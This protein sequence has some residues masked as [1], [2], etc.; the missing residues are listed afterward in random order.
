MPW[1]SGAM[2]GNGKAIQMT[3]GLDRLNRQP[4]HFLKI[5]QTETLSG[6][7]QANPS[8]NT[9]TEAGGRTTYL[10]GF[11]FIIIT[12]LCFCN[13][14]WPATF[15][16]Y[17]FAGIEASRWQEF[18]DTDNRLLSEN[19]PRLTLGA[20]WESIPDS[21]R[22]RFNAS[23]RIYFAALSYDGQ[24]QSPIAANSNI[25][26]SSTS[27]YSGFS[28]ELETRFN[29]GSPS[30]AGLLN[31][32]VDLWRRDIDNA[33]DAKGNSVSG[34]TEDYQ[35]LY[36]KL[37][38]QKATQ[39]I[40]GRSLLSLGIKYPLKIDEHASG[41]SQ[42]LH[43]DRA[44]SLFVAY[45]VDLTDHRQTSINIYYE[46]LRLS[47]SPTVAGGWYQPRSHQDTVGVTIGT[48]F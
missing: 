10:S 30:L 35:V 19:G 29:L 41:I 20:N 26:I 25:Y 7:H 9:A 23:S 36:S 42:T 14:A 24:T 46:G 45:R 11:I 22:L 8:S 39:D 31:I 34:F 15:D 48:P 1:M 16:R 18:S 40:Y 5:R 27:R 44:V 21:R 43:P 37:G 3:I 2:N 32:G 13:T 28:A 4:C 47:A 12:G 17:I 38:V 6:Q 33:R